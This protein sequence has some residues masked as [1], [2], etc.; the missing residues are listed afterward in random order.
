MIT[1]VGLVGF[2]PLTTQKKKKKKRQVQ[3]LT[4][5]ACK[6]DLN[7]GIGSLLVE[8]RTPRDHPGF[9]VHPKSKKK[10]EGNLMHTGRSCE[11]GGRD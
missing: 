10:G 1:V 7:G 2:P 6:C 4:P 8:L 11:D 3:V 9:G 5:C